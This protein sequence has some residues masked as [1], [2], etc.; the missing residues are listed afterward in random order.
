[1]VYVPET[2]YETPETSP[3]SPLEVAAEE[4]AALDAAEEERE[5]R[6]AALRGKSG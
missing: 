6:N 3:T 2:V 5:A 4:E 1:M